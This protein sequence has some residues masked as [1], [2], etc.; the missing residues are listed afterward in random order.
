LRPW[1]G[2]ISSVVFSAGMT[3]VQP[4]RLSDMDVVRCLFE[5]NIISA[6]EILRVLMVC[7]EGCGVLGSVVFVSSAA[8]LKGE[9]GAAVYCATKAALDGLVRALAAEFAPNVRVNAVLP[10]IMRTPM[11]VQTLE[12]ADALARINSRYL[13]GVGEVVDAV[14]LICILLDKRSSWITG[15]SYVVDGGRAIY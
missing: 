4:I 9:R 7:D 5:V 10:G 13:L 3:L 8:G 6:V 14:S 15:Q 12:D 1:A 11:T 2:L